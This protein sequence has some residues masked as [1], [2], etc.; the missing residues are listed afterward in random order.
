MKKLLA[1]LLRI[2]RPKLEEE[3]CQRRQAE[4]K[5]PMQKV[6]LDHPQFNLPT[7]KSL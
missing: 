5:C 7:K 3:I 2:R 4:G 1:K 6:F